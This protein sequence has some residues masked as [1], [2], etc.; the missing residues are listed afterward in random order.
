LI[1]KLDKIHQEK[2]EWE[3]EK[4]HIKSKY[5]IDDTVINLNVGGQQSLMVGQT[6]LC[7]VP[8]STLSTLF[9]GSHELKKVDGQIFLDRDGK[10]FTHLINYLRNSRRSY[11]EFADTND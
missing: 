9:S 10:T 1:K 3:A 5:R 11:P 7:S 4:A 2:Q 6:V 8:D